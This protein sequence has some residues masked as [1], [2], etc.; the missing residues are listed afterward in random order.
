MI[1]SNQL[2]GEVLNHLS[3]KS[4]AGGSDKRRTTRVDLNARIDVAILEK[5]APPR[6]IAVFIRDISIE[7]TGLLSGVEMRKDQ[8]LVVVLPRSNSAA[9]CVL[10]IVT[11]CAPLADGIFNIGCKFVKVIEPET[12]EKLHVA[13]KDV[14]RNRDSVL[15]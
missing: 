15:A 2:Y 1:L 8:H 13:A 12:F 4:L 9:A 14:S 3:V 7:G 11:F 5:G 6:Q 10:C